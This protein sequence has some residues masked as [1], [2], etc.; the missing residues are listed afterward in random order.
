MYLWWV[1]VSIPFHNLTNIP[2]R[3]SS[4][5]LLL[6]RRCARRPDEPFRHRARLQ[7]SLLPV[8]LAVGPFKPSINCGGLQP[9]RTPS[10]DS[11]L[12]ALRI[13]RQIICS[14]PQGYDTNFRERG[15][16]STPSANLP[17]KNDTMIKLEQLCTINLIDAALPNEKRLTNDEIVPPG[18]LEIIGEKSEKK[19]S[20]EVKS[21]VYLFG[22]ASKQAIEYIEKQRSQRNSHN[23][24]NVPTEA[25][26]KTRGNWESLA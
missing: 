5:F 3:H 16:N 12:Y 13:H 14:T 25:W 15:H 18:Y 8:E 6:H 10:L 11:L 20:H 9:P 4:G 23:P 7:R 1:D 21:R 19:R 22:P 17:K 26:K 2:K 24:N